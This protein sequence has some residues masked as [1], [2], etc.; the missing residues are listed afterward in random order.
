MGSSTS[1]GEEQSSI[2]FT[3]S[4]PENKFYFRGIKMYEIYKYCQI[5]GEQRFSDEEVKDLSKKDLTLEQFNK[6]YSHIHT[7]HG[8]ICNSYQ[9][10]TELFK[11]IGEFN[12]FDL[13]LSFVDNKTTTDPGNTLA[14]S[15]PN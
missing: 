4:I 1:K 13:Q 3:S 15:N 10:K 2:L 7:I 8:F 12:N 11:K 9:C 5:C 14:L 6:K